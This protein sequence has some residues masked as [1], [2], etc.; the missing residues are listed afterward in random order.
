MKGC[1]VWRGG[2]ASLSDRLAPAAGEVSCPPQEQ[3]RPQA[4]RPF[5]CTTGV[6][7]ANL[8]PIMALRCR[9]IF[10]RQVYDIHYLAP[11]TTS[12]RP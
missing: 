9:L 8:P 1:C 12:E 3:P 6:G 2:H 10:T 11:Q 5:A 4:R 7:L